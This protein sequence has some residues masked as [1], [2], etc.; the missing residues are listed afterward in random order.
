MAVDL[1]RVAMVFAAGPAGKQN[2]SGYAL[3]ERSVLT[4]AH[5]LLQAGTGPRCVCWWS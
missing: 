4:A 2:G 1:A 3:G 5:M